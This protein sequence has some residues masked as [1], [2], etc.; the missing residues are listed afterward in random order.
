MGV[1]AGSDGEAPLQEPF[2]GARFVVNE[3]RLLGWDR[4]GGDRLGGSV[5]FG[6][7]WSGGC[8]EMC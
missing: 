8:G 2:D 1:F 6:L 4:R 5:G 7:D 3:D